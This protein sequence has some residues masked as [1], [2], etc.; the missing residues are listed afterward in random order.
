MNQRETHQEV[1]GRLAALSARKREY[2]KRLAGTH[3]PQPASRRGSGWPL[4]FAQERMWFLHM[5]DPGSTAYTLCYAARLGALDP[6]AF[7]DALNTVIARH[8][9]LRT[10]FST[11][12]G[13]PTQQVRAALRITVGRVDATDRRDPLAAAR[14]QAELL[15]QTPFDLTRDPLVRSVLV[16]VSDRSWVALMAFHHIILDAWSIGRLMTE[17]MA[18]YQAVR[19]GAAPALAPLALQYGDYA[20]WQRNQVSGGRL[21][22]LLTWWREELRDAAPLLLPTDR[23]RP[24]VRRDRGAEHTF[25]VDDSVAQALR[26]LARTEHATL[27][28]CLL[29][30]YAI[31][32]SRWSGQDEASVGTPVEGRTRTEF[33]PLIGLFLNTVVLRV[34]L[35]GIP[36]FRTLLRL[37]R[38]ITLDAHTHRE[39]PFERLV[40][41]LVPQR[42]LGQTPLFQ[43]MFQLQMPTSSVH[44]GP[45]SAD[46]RVSPPRRNSLFDVSLDM[47]DGPTGLRGRFEYSTDLFDASTI[48]RMGEHYVTLLS[49]IA[50]DPEQPIGGLDML[51]DAERRRII[52]TNRT[53]A[54]RPSDGVHRLVAARADRTPQAPA[55]MSSSGMVSYAE[56]RGRADELAGHLAACGAGPDR[57]VA[58][59]LDR[60]VELAV[61]QLAVLHAGAAFLPLDS[62]APPARLDALLAQ[63]QPVAVLTSTKYARPFGRP[64]R[65][66]LLD[67]PLPPQ[68]AVPA[69]AGPGNL[70]YLI[71]T[72]GTTGPPKVVEVTHASLTNHG[73]AM[74]DVLRLGPGD[75]VFQLASPAFDVQ[76]E[77][78][79]PTLMA[80]ATAV[81]PRADRLIGLDVL[82]YEIERAGATVLNMPTPLWHEW[83]LAAEAGHADVPTCLRTVVIGSDRVIPDDLARWWVL[84]PPRPRLL[85]AYGVS[86]ATV[87]SLVHEVPPEAGPGEADVIG[88]PIR[89]VE[90]DVLDSTGSLVPLGV[91]G[92]LYLAGAGLARGYRG[93]PAGTRAA[94]GPHVFAPERRLYRTGDVAVRRADGALRFL[95]RLDDR[96]KVRGIRVELEEVATHL[97]DHPA[98]RDAVVV[99]RG[100]ALAAYLVPANGSAPTPYE[101]QAHLAARMPPAQVPASYTLLSE[102][103]LTAHGKLDRSAL[104]APIR[105]TDLVDGTLVTATEETIAALWRE[106]L[107]HDRIGRHENFFDLGGHSLL[108]VRAHA[109]LQ[110][111]LC[112][113]LTILDLFRHPTVQSL[114]ARIE[115][116]R[117]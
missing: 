19:A 13:Q 95:G 51:T 55:I 66:I 42:Q 88:R 76:L 12:D 86:E 9:V 96:V 114:A 69:A 37:V 100:D 78:L 103:P 68:R 89:N 35:A 17:L 58:L 52:A 32:L 67:R 15:A 87:T 110:H 61:A 23:P 97:R 79:W 41:E 72:S 43:T 109:R 34:R 20:A 21:D 74:V 48:T 65:V 25:R 90:A 92:E 104:P 77:E 60:T 40:Q 1:A 11:V 29:A 5:L 7:E 16:R 117:T 6:A 44:K 70:A 59:L 84:P 81:L 113:N 3:P 30:A 82:T 8:E 46:D 85:Q 115:E 91:P 47:F 39:L 36:D 14:E 106:F 111:T 112:T 4:S 101:L 18:A 57:V 98:V 49:S 50:A 10:S 75:R 99:A 27:F 63:V 22:R 80:G 94:F 28:M 33:E 116:L 38:Q 2:L 108:A 107:G 26:A 83:L 45:A 73:C 102:L 71:A 53:S 64:V 24:A 93:D 56:L 105:P 31:L 62:A 54:P